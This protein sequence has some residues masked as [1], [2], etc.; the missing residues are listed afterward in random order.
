MN[1][2]IAILRNRV[3]ALGLQFVSE[4]VGIDNLDYIQNLPA[5]EVINLAMELDL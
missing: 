1:R 3:L 5:F 4:M 2:S